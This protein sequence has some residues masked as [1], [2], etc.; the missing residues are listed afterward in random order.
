M[1]VRRIS[2]IQVENFKS[3]V[4]FEMDLA[5]F[6]CL[7]GLN[8]AG[9]STVLQFIDLLSQL[10]RGDMKG[11]LSE[12]KWKA[13]DLKS[14]LTKKLNVEFCVHFCDENGEPAGLGKQSTIRRRTNRYWCR[15]IAP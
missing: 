9:K 4:D 5:K 10:I 1:A 14:K 3:L 15:P 11:W 8:G 12:R 2:R 13:T 7:V 6:S